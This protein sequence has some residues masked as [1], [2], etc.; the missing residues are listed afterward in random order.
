MKK[1]RNSQTPDCEYNADSKKKHLRGISVRYW[2]QTLAI[3]QL[4]RAMCE[5]MPGTCWRQSCSSKV[6]KDLLAA[7]SH[8][9]GFICSFS[10]R[11]QFLNED[12]CFT[13]RTYKWLAL[14]CQAWSLYFTRPIMNAIFLS[15]IC[16]PPFLKSNDSNF[17]PSAHFL[18]VSFNSTWETDRRR[19]EKWKRAVD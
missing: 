1:G 13:L 11:A 10:Y 9:V 14:T 15:K 17:F 16:I 8:R 19:D 3:W 7:L 18:S 4:G 12:G 5:G 2:G 6:F